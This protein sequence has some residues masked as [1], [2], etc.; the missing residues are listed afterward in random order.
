MSTTLL[1]LRTRVRRL[2]DVVGSTF[3]TDA[4]L[5]ERI[6]VAYKELYGLLVRNSL[7]RSETTYTVTANGAA[8]YALPANFLGLIGVYRSVGEDFVPLERFDDKFKPGSRTG[9]ASKYR[10]VGS[11]LVLYPKPSSGTYD[12]VYIPV[13]GDM[14]ADADTMDGVLGWEE[15]VVLDAAIYVLEKE[16]S[17]TSK[18]EF[19]RD[20]IL[21]RIQDEAQIAEFTQAP[22]IRNTRFV[23]NSDPDSLSFGTDF[24]WDGLD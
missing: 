17:D 3:V 16:E 22:R 5:T 21:K 8:S 15:F 2:A 4:E 23:G 7:Q 6:N 11:N 20:R 14:A 9:D 18:L 24:E 13:P 1:Q 12:V 19:K 10:V